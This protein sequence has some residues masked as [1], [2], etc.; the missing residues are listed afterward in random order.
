MF[1]FNAYINETSL[2]IQRVRFLDALLFCFSSFRETHIFL[3]R[4]I[5]HDL[6][7]IRKWFPHG[8]LAQAD[9]VS[10]ASGCDDR[11]TSTW[12]YLLSVRG[13]RAS[14]TMTY[15]DLMGLKLS[16]YVAL[17]S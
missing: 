1:V 7:R 2:L 6:E 8:D 5:L 13:A 12:D 14:L 10:E 17:I 3:K 11:F 9:A 16:V 15:C 4:R